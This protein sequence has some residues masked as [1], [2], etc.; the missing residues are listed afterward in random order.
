MNQGIKD[1]VKQGVP[2][3]Y[4]EDVMRKFIPSN[5]DEEKRKSIE[6]KAF[7]QMKKFEDESGVMEEGGV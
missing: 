5:G 3:K 2:E 1:A 7:R 4:V 6:E